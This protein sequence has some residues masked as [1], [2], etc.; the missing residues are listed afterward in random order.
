[1]I[2]DRVDTLILGGGTTG[3]VV[4]G[5][6]GERSSEVI[7]VVEAGPD[8]GPLGGGRWPDRLVNAAMLGVG[9]HDWGYTSGRQ[10]H[11]R[12]VNF[13]RARVIGGCSSHNGCAAIWG[14][15][16]DYDSWGLDGWSTAELE[17]FLAASNRRLRVTVPD[18]GDLT[19][20]QAATLAAFEAAGIPAVNDLN[21]LDHAEGVA[22][23]PVNVDAGVRFNTAFAYLDPVRHN[24]NLHVASDTLAVRVLVEAERVVGAELLH[25][26]RPIMVRAAR[27]IVAGG[28]YGSPGIL[29]RSGIGD[30]RLLG[31][32]GIPVTHPLPGVGANLHDHPA[33]QLFCAGTDALVRQMRVAATTGFCPEEQI[34]AKV[35]S[36]IA[37]E[38]FDLHLYPVGGPAHSGAD[39]YFFELDAACLTPRS[40]GTCH[41]ATADPAIAPTIDHAFLTDEE[42]HDQAVLTAGVALLREMIATEPFAS[43]VGA[44]IAGPGDDV[45]GTWVHYYHPVGTC[46]MGSGQD[47]AAVVDDRCRI[48][49]LADGYIA[50]CS[51]I[52]VVPRANTNVP[53][54][55]IGERVASWL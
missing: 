24:P 23:S 41:V 40:R 55:M 17:P 21:D 37:T 9:V 47:A 46:R 36:P 43:I 32:L 13:E 44:E 28:T 1:M 29:E 3:C 52:P 51:I 15:R 5:L 4:A 2:P 35:R 11:G 30:P 42:G 39:D 25:R 7:L 6:L 16:A 33:V 22:P 8:Y 18:R 12:T 54:V 53:A 27:T 50:D 31:P 19:P 34:I 26:G 45:T 14:S 38:A 20:Y 48:H 49:G 10:V